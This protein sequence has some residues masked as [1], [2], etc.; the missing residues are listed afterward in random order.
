MFRVQRAVS[1]GLHKSTRL[2]LLFVTQRKEL[3][4]GHIVPVVCVNG[5]PHLQEQGCE[6][7]HGISGN[8]HA[9]IF[10]IP[11]WMGDVKI[12]VR[13]IVTSGEAHLSVDDGDF[14]VIPVVQEQVHQR[15]NRIEHSALNAQRSHLPN[16]L[17]VDKGDA[18]HV[19][20]ED[21]NIQTFLSFFRQYLFNFPEGFQI[22]DGV[23]FHKDELLRLPK[24]FFLFFQCICC[25]RKELNIAVGIYRKRAM[26]ADVPSLICDG[27][28]HGFHLR[29]DV[30]LL[31]QKPK[32]HPVDLFEA[33]AHF[34]SGSIQSH[35]QI[36]QGARHGKGQQQ[37]KPGHLHRW[38]F[39]HAEKG[40]A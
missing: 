28:I 32:Q 23:I 18:A 34:P 29:K 8:L 33:H 14:A 15:N 25:I 39:V 40:D 38:G 17:I 5:V 20:V 37:N 19:I 22:L 10:P 1:I 2:P 26:S 6:I 13:Q 11:I 27:K 30:I 12:L 31:G 3:H 24:L 7:T 9:G 36:D 21:S 35:D 16:E 4:E